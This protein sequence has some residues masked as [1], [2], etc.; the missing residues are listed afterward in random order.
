MPRQI[1][2]FLIVFVNVYIEGFFFSITS[3]YALLS[4]A[5]TIY[6]SFL[7]SAKCFFS[8]HHLVPFGN[9]NTHCGL[10]NPGTLS[11]LPSC[12]YFDSIACTTWQ[13]RVNGRHT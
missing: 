8:L 13:P 11:F 10:R 1:F 12:W 9:D 5:L 7:D 2:S 6:L 3:N 4:T